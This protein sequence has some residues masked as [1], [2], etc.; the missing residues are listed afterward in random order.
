MTLSIT[1]VNEPPRTSIE[2]KRE[3]KVPT[4]L[5]PLCDVT[6]KKARMQNLSVLLLRTYKTSDF[7]AAKYILVIIKKACFQPISI[8]T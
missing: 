8:K 2:L 1:H 4:G 3:N 6:H 7:T 5:S